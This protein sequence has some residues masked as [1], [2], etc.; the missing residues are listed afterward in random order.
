[1]T[2]IEEVITMDD[3]ETLRPGWSAL[4]ERC[5]AATPFQ[6][7]EWLL[8]WYR[9]F[10]A[11]NPLRV[12]ALR[13]GNRLVGLAPL[14]LHHWRGR[15][16]LS[17]LGTG[18][19]DRLDILL[20]PGAEESGARL[21]L[22]HL[23]EHRDRWDVCDLEQLPAACPLLRAPVP[24]GLA[25]CTEEQ[26]VCPTLSLPESVE[27]LVGAA[28]SRLPAKLRYYRRRVERIG[29]VRF[30]TADE[31]K[32]DEFLGV[33]FRL[34]RARWREAG[35]EGML[36]DSDVREFHR[37]IAAGFL[38]R[39]VLRLSVLRIGAEIAAAYYGFAA[40]G[41][42]YYYI[43]GWDP[44]FDRL[45]VGHLLVGHAIG[46]AIRE[47]ATEFDFLRG[48]EGYKYRWGAEDQP[49]FRRRLW[50]GADGC[51]E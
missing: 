35:E 12:L 3:L 45:S 17:L 50:H 18:I 40:K 49:G 43:G 30:E 10:A 25:A 22:E 5:P 15:R 16:Q 23:G 44:E 24:D 19:T 37:E 46:E 13:R 48:R 14:F 33:L 36:H 9:H 7:P 41:R 34:H 4:W 11:P 51:R 20:E 38:A 27:E 42:A 6:A 39:G 1:M 28:S 47:G 32:L 8:P 29:P 31:A 2:E 26:D 21:I